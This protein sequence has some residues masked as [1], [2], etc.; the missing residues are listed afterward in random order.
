MVKAGADNDS[1]T[2]G[3]TAKQTVYG[4]KGKDTFTYDEA[5][6]L[7]FEDLIAGDDGDD[8]LILS[9]ADAGVADEDFSTVT[10]VETFSFTGASAA[11]L[12]HVFGAKA[13]TAGIRTIDLSDATTQKAVVDA[14]AFTTGITLTAADANLDDSLVGGSGADTFNSGDDGKVDFKGNGGNDT[15]NITSAKL[16]QVEDLSGSDILKVASSNTA[17][18][19]ATVTA[20]F[21]ATAASTNNL[22]VAGVT[23]I[24]TADAKITLTSAGNTYGY[25]VTGQA[26][27]VDGKGSSV[28][29]SSK[30]DAI[31]G[32]SGTG[33]DTFKGGAGNDTIT[34]NGGVDSLAGEAGTD[35]FVFTSDLAGS[36]S[37]SGGGDSGDNIVI[38]TQN[39]VTATVD[40]DN[41]DVLEINTGLQ[42]PLELWPTCRHR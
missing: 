4:G 19:Q 15:F 13:Q 8:V 35:T 6:E 32:G 17:G 16:A 30:G 5:G 23:L 29:G 34:G 14:S 41:V 22:S 38:E 7:T 31:T 33:N 20:D 37:I 36:D 26:A 25:T 18:T 3:G 9:T 10:S 27:N 28:V 40:F 11:S 12:T 24:G 42:V 1:I 39:G 2:F 21:T